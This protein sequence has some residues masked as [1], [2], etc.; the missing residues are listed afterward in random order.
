MY[1]PLADVDK[2][3]RHQKRLTKETPDLILVIRL[4]RVCL[5]VGA[6]FPPKLLKVSLGSLDLRLRWRPAERQTIGESNPFGV[7]LMPSAN[8]SGKRGG[9]I[10]NQ[11][12]VHHKQ[13]LR[14]DGGC[15]A[16]AIHDACVGKIEQLKSVIQ[17]IADHGQVR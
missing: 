6:G 14:R 15:R 13:S 2:F 7:I 4:I 12:A 3:I 5:F 11:V 17:M 1:L 10:G 16:V 8:S 9:R